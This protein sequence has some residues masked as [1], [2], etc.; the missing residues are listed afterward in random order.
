MHNHG[1]SPL[2]L[3]IR[4]DISI[5]LTATLGAPSPYIAVS[6]IGGSISGIESTTVQCT[7]FAVRP[8]RSSSGFEFADRTSFEIVDTALKGTHIAIG[9]IPPVTHLKHIGAF[10]E[11]IP[12][13]LG[14]DT[15]VFPGLQVGRE[16]LCEATV[17]IFG[18]RTRRHRFG[19]NDH[20]IAVLHLP[21]IRIAE[22]ER[23]IAVV[24]SAQTE[25][26]ILGPC[27]KVRRSGTH[28][29]LAVFVRSGFVTLTRVVDI[30]QF[31][32]FVIDYTTGTEGCILLTGA[33]GRQHF[34]HRGIGSTIGSTDAPQGVEGLLH[35]LLEIMEIKDLVILLHRVEERQR[36]T[37]RTCRRNIV[38][39]R[40]CLIGRIEIGGDILPVLLLL[41]NILLTGS[42]EG[43]KEHCTKYKGYDFL[44]FHNVL[45]L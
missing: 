17:F 25:E 40:S 23:A 37:Y 45:L 32:R 13:H 27:L 44:G 19:G 21:D 20:M 4:T 31:L 28:N 1:T 26:L 24:P 6:T 8:L 39:S 3:G 36:V 22:I 14:E 16:E 29:D 7:L 34:A 5:V 10:E 15:F 38:G 42:Q 18:T 33:T 43:T 30:V 9:Q 41:R 35:I 2:R 11:T 12:N